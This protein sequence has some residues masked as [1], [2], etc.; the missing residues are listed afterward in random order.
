MF[1]FLT[2]TIGA[3]AIA[4]IFYGFS[5]ASKNTLPMRLR[6][7]NPVQGKTKSE[8]IAAIGNP[9]G[10]TAQEG[11]KTLLQWMIP[12]YHV[13]LLFDANDI[14]EGVTHEFSG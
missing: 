14:C 8:I 6:R 13:A 4:G 3:L 9:N 12:G 1:E 7:I 2:L 10:I 5:W 11:G